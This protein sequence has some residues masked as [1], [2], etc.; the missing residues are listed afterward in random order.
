MAALLDALQQTQVIAMLVGLALLLLWEHAHP[1][2]AFFRK[3]PKER[4]KH[5]LR[6]L[7]L[8]GLNAVVIS[9]IFVGLW[10]AAAIGAE[11]QGI[12]LLHWLESALGLPLWAHALGA[13]LL[14]DAW[15]YV[16]HRI[17]HVIPFLWR[18]H[19]VHHHDPNMDVT[20]ASRFHVGEV[21]IS[22]FLRIGVIVLFGVYLWELV[23]YETVMFAVVQFHHANIRLPDRMDRALRAVIVTPN[24]HK[25]HHSR[26]QPETDSN[27]S[28]LFSFWDRI[29]RSFR[30]R[31]DPSTLEF[32]LDGW[33]DAEEQ[34]I[35]G[36]LWAPLKPPNVAALASEG[37]RLEEED[38]VQ[39]DSAKPPHQT[40]QCH[41]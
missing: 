17:N 1:F 23:L 14:L 20:T 41:G 4:G 6:N 10:G 40:R 12:G 36:M 27:Y 30:L 37:L 19:R 33:D 5:A 31:D 8:G 39:L 35:M 26:W 11:R 9:V 34:Q 29:G 7:L 22:S 25:V 13:I 24:M 3:D 38:D 16:W 2:F 21:A 15:M 32:G 18:F 28:S